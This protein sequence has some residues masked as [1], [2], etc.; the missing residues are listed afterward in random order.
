M[1][2]VTRLNR[3]NRR[4]LIRV[5]TVYLLVCVHHVKGQDIPRVPIRHIIIYNISATRSTLSVLHHRMN[6]LRNKKC[7][8]HLKIRNNSILIVRST[9]SMSI[10]S[11]RI[12]NPPVNRISQ[13]TPMP[14][15][16]IVMLMILPS[17]VISTNTSPGLLINGITIRNSSVILLLILLSYSRIIVLPHRP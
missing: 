17:N 3:F 1:N 7:P 8:S 9:L 2:I 10:R 4:R 6:V 16:H 11:I 15:S 14:L 5:A 12:H 13:Y